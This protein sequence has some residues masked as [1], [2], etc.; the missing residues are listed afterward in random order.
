MSDTRKLHPVIDFQPQDVQM[1]CNGYI[2]FEKS[3]RPKL[4]KIAL[5]QVAMAMAMKTVLD[6]V[7][8]QNSI[9]ILSDK[10]DALDSIL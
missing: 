9:L 5:R 1:Y 4:F 2:K 10:S 8:K 7:E 3:F 6:T